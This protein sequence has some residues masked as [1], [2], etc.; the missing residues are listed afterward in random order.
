MSSNREFQVDQLGIFTPKKFFK[1]SLKTGEVGFI[2]AGI[3]AIDGAPVGDTI[4]LV[5]M[6]AEQAL[7]RVYSRTT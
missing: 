4:T 2:I 1:E 7:P 6:P 3:K 5:K